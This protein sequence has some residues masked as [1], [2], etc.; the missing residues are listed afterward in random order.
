MKKSFL[1]FIIPFSFIL[2]YFNQDRTA[3]YRV[4]QNKIFSFTKTNHLKGITSL[5][6]DYLFDSENIKLAKIINGTIVERYLW[7]GEGQLLAVTTP[8]GEILRQ[9]LYDTPTATLPRQMKVKDKL[10]KFIFN[11]MRSLRV[12]LDE[13]NQIVKIINYDENGFITKDTFPSLK[14]D[15]AYAGGIWDEDAKLL[16]FPQGVY[17]LFEQKWISKIKDIDIIE[18]LKQLNNLNS[19]EVYQCNATLDVYY[20]AYLCTKNQC[21]GFYAKDYLKYFN[22]QGSMINNSIYFNHARCKQINLP[23]DYDA[24]IFSQCVTKRITS[25]QDSTFDAFSHNCHHEVSDIINTCKAQA[26]KDS[27]E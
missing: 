21:G 15:F 2:F 5:K 19:H 1:F 14:I 27:H 6:L 10:Y 8:Q 7:G 12:V 20:H 23:S 11:P 17:D 4:T 9:Y 13:Q 24:E 25:H 16:F 18:N 26:K 22:A 3:L